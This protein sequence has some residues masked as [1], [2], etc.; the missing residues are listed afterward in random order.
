M[1]YKLGELLKAL[2]DKPTEQP[3]RAQLEAC[4]GG[5]ITFRPNSELRY[6]LE[7]KAKQLGDLSL[8][9]FVTT[10]L[11]ALKDSEVRPGEVNISNYNDSAKQIADR[12]RLLFFSHGYLLDEVTAILK[13]HGVTPSTFLNDVRLMDHLS[14]E[15]ISELSDAFC[16]TR[17][18]LCDPSET[19]MGERPT[20]RHNSRAIL[21]K[22]L[23]CEQ[24]RTLEEVIPLCKLTDLDGHRLKYQDDEGYVPVSL[25]IKL[26]PAAKYKHSR[27]FAWTT[28]RFDY[29]DARIEYKA[30]LLTLYERYGTRSFSRPS[31]LGQALDEQMFNSV[32]EGSNVI[33]M[34]PMAW[35]ACNW[36]AERY[37]EAKTEDS[38]PFE[39]S[40]MPS[41]RSLAKERH[42]SLLEQFNT[43]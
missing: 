13:D 39:E 15:M 14:E 31:F 34:Q 27:F 33:D 36:D 17:K 41:V 23:Q 6:Y 19:A 3:S 43:E 35:R 10:V 9:N 5:A 29:N 18:W 4:E 11:S 16:V 30:L 40:E 12:V 37:V 32:I 24:E 1:Q 28:T 20:N 42:R 21:S 26:T 8:S 7:Q 22:I 38:E 2:V 25:A